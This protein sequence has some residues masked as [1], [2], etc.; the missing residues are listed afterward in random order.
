MGKGLLEA[1]T[2]GTSATSHFIDVPLVYRKTFT[3]LQ[4]EYV[5]GAAES[6]LCQHGAM[7]NE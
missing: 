7:K 6:S 4:A 3:H 2:T 5:I 1:I